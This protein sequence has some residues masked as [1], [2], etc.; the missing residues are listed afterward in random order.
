MVSLCNIHYSAIYND[1]FRPYIWAIIRLLVEPM[2][3]LYIRS[4]GGG[5]EISSYIILWGSRLL[6]LHVIYGYHVESLVYITDLALHCNAYYIVIPSV[7]FCV[8]DCM[9]M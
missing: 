4:F 9:Y 6:I 1:M 3:I 8:S 2:G 5:D 7:N